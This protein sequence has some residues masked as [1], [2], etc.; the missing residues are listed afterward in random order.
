MK[1][2]YYLLPEKCSSASSIKVKNLP[3]STTETPLDYYL[4]EC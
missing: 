4:N 3:Y 1:R 2:P